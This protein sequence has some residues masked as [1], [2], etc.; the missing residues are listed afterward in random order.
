MIK[1]T[2]KQSIKVLENLK[3]KNYH[4]YAL[5]N[6]SAETFKGMTTE[7]PFLNKFDGL[8]ISGEEKIVKPNSEIYE[9]A[10]NRFNL[11]PNESVFIDDNLDNINAAK[12][13][14]FKTIHLINPLEIKLKIE[15][16]LD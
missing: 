15:Q 8:I 2:Y 16:F 14:G 10:I 5:S 6:W 11:I 12:D 7:Y 3:C 1:G 13:L 9:L 4:C